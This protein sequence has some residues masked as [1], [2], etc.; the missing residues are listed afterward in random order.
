MKKNEKVSEE[1]DWSSITA[2]GQ[3]QL[4]HKSNPTSAWVYNWEKNLNHVWLS[5]QDAEVVNKRSRAL[6]SSSST[7]LEVQLWLLRS[8]IPDWSTFLKHEG[9]NKYNNDQL[10]FLLCVRRHPVLM[11]AYLRLFD[12]QHRLGDEAVKCHG[13]KPWQLLKGL[14]PHR[15]CR[16]TSQMSD[17]SSESLLLLV[18]AEKLNLGHSAATY[19]VPTLMRH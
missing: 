2:L 12:K 4:L 6:Q 3:N 7:Q 19:V 5:A 1:P 18:Y 13:N 10:L 9:E 15:R 11:L 17:R 14:M 16:F 8:K